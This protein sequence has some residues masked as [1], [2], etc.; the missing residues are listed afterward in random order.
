MCVADVGFDD[1]TVVDVKQ[2]FGELEDSVTNDILLH[3]LAENFNRVYVN[4]EEPIKFSSKEEMINNY[5]KTLL[6]NK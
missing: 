1:A 2:V 5:W 4:G 6:D 3:Y